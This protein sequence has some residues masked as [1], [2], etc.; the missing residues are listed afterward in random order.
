MSG[1]YY[2]PVGFMAS[3]IARTEDAI[4]RSLEY[5]EGGI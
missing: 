3:E 1:L 4:E 2:Y 5:L